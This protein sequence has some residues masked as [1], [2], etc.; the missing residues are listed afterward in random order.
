MLRREEPGPRCLIL[1]SG[2][3]KFY[4]PDQDPFTNATATNAQGKVMVMVIA[5]LGPG[6]MTA[7]ELKQAA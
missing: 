6:V 5:E 3:I 7:L 1:G 2:V 4:V